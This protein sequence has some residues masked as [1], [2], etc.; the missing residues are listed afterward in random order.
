MVAKDPCAALD[1][2]Q[3]MAI[4]CAALL[5]VMQEEASRIRSRARAR[6]TIVDRPIDYLNTQG[7]STPLEDLIEL[8]CA[9][10]VR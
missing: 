10:S 3:G 8:R 4:G 9:G 7:L 5:P 2:H 6:P 1:L